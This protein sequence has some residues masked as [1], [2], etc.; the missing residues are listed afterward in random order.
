MPINVYIDN[1]AGRST[2]KTGIGYFSEHLINELSAKKEVNTYTYKIGGESDSLLA[3]VLL[4]TYRL[5]RYA[6][7][8]LSLD[9]TAKLSAHDIVIGANYLIPPT[10]AFTLPV[11]HDLCFI[12]HP[13]WVQGRNAMILRTMLPKTL[14][15]S[16]GLITISEFS[17]ERIRKV[18]KY[19]KPILV[20]P[21]PPMKSSV[22]QIRPAGIDGIKTGSYFLF[23]STIEPRKNIKTMLDAFELL[24]KTTQ[25]HHPLILA[26]KPG[27][28]PDT[29]ERLRRNDNPNIHYLEYVSESER[30][31]L[32]GGALATIIPSHYEGFGMMT[33]ESLDAGTPTITSDI[34]PHREILG[35]TG[36]Y[37]EP[38]D[39]AALK[40]KMEQFIKPGYRDKA[41][42]S[43]SAIL[44]E[45]SWDKTAKQV[46]NF[47]EETIK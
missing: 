30:N 47:I 20:I 29:L 2:T 45:Y 32:Y 44:G 36:E 15:R 23:I 3:K 9:F 14:D 37:F 42:V 41:K 8:D 34:P 38:L 22:E 12:D 33:L 24:P 40:D 26:G 13:E 31:W 35:N 28:D 10:R 43:Q 27:W 5:L 19:Q 16:S 39:T 4:K 46:L 7:I 11:I 17:A 25:A 18:Y 6:Q 1:E 21:I